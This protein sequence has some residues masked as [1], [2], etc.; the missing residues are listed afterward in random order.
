MSTA[1]SG[2]RPVRDSLLLIA[3]L[4]SAFLPLLLVI[5]Y[6]LTSFEVLSVFLL[7]TAFGLVAGWLLRRHT[8]MQ[9]ALVSVLVYW[10]IDTYFVQSSAGATLAVLAGGATYYLLRSKWS[11]NV[12][13]MLLVF[14]VVWSVGVLLKQQPDLLV[15]PMSPTSAST[16][17]TDLRPVVHFI[18][19]EQ[20][21]PTTLPETIPPQHP[22]LAAAQ[23]YIARGFQFHS[24]VASTSSN[25]Q[26]SITEAF[27]LKHGKNVASPRD[28]AFS[29][30]IVD[31]AY[32]DLLG[33]KGYNITAVQSNFLEFCVPSETVSCHTYSRGNNGRAMARF[34][35]SLTDRLALVL[36]ELHSAYT[37][38]NHDNNV[39]LYRWIYVA[40]RRYDIYPTYQH[41]F[42]SRPA[43]VMNVLDRIEESMA[44]IRPGNAYVYHLLLPHFPYMLD[45]ACNLKPHEEWSAPNR[46]SGDFKLPEDKIYRGYWDQSACV[47]RRLMAIIDRIKASPT[48]KEAVI[49]VHGDHGARVTARKTGNKQPEDVDTIFALFDPSLPAQEI[50]EPQELQSLF[51]R[52]ILQVSR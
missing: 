4:L 20:M 13:P 51:H 22:I 29:H 15:P 18:I 3:L 42:Y 21:S 38:K 9:Q 46:Y 27:L 50:T 11:D 23:D 52:T 8:R 24:R 12:R 31:N 17:R 43:V 26:F 6:E 49:I 45:A 7:L 5:G 39:F 40:L 19:D 41:M 25:T 48:G 16:A 47:H 32:F 36:Y 14:G 35:G 37:R 44:S 34:P 1:S 2:Y 28:E 33:A 10:I 30:R